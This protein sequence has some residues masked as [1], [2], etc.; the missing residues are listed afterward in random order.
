MHGHLAARLDPLGSEPIGD[1]ALE[2]RDGRPDA[3]G[4]GA[5]P[6]LGAAHRGARARRSPRRCRT[7]ATPTA[8]RSPTR[9][10][11]SPTT[12]SACGCASAIESRRVPPPAPPEEKR[13]PAD[14][15]DRRRGA[16]DLPAQGV[17]RPE[18]LLDRGP[19]HA[20]PDARRD[21]RAGR[22]RR[23]AGGVHR[24]GA[25][26]PAERAGARRRP[27]LR[28]R[29]WPSSRA[30]RTST[31]GRRGR[32][33]APATSSTTRARR[34][35]TRPIDG[36]QID[37]HARRQPEPPRVRRPGR[38]GPHARATRPIAPAPSRSTTRS[39]ALPILIHGDAAFPGEGVVAETLNL[40]GAATATRPAARS[41][42]SPTTRSASRPSRSSRARPA[43]RPTS[44]RAST[45]RSCTSTP[46]TPRPASRRCGW[47]WPTAR[48]SAAAS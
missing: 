24:D 28:R 48:S 14:A 43:T 46:T 20:G 8:A 26:R 39:V 1:P 45:C 29:S 40:E 42:S 18:E 31:C 36:K 21:L 17:P 16:R 30:R 15:T 33:A 2:P 25:P 27:A 10:S 37:G 9:S 12:A 11:T 13:A 41:T 3:R 47:R 23:R 6:G 4:D 44:P 7:C 19:R 38:R 34:A 22:A 32:A 35:P 5:D